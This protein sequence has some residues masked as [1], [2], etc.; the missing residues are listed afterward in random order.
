MNYTS[1]NFLRKLD[2]KVYEKAAELVKKSHQDR[3]AGPVDSCFSCNA[4]WEAA[5]TGYRWGDSYTREIHLNAYKA[6]FEPKNEAEEAAHPFWNKGVEETGVPSRSFR[7]HKS[8]RI[9]AL[10]MMAAIVRHAKG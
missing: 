8:E 7:R 4:V 6:F 10:A 5:F 2:P 9:M 3:F 1:R